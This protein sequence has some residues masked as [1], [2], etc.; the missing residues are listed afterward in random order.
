MENRAVIKWK[1]EKKSTKFLAQK[2]R[3]GTKNGP[4]S[5]QEVMRKAKAETIEEKNSKE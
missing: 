1:N 3:K 5:I 2:S 4:K